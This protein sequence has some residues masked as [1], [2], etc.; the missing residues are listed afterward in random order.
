MRKLTIVAAALAMVLVFA[1]AAVAKTK[2]PDLVTVTNF[3]AGPVISGGPS[4]CVTFSFDQKVFLTGGD[5]TNFHLVP[6][7]GDDAVDGTSQSSNTCRDRRGDRLITVIFRGDL[8]AADFAR[9][10]VDNSTV[11]SNRQGNAPTNV[12]QAEDI[13]PGTETVNPDL[14]SVTVNCKRQVA[15]YRFDE[16]LSQ[17]DVIQDTS[18]LRLYFG[19]T[20][21][22]SAQRVDET[23]NRKVLRASF[24]G[25]LPQGKNLRG[26]RGAFVTAG[27]VVGGQP[28]NGPGGEAGN[29]FDEVAP[30]RFA[31]NCGG[32][33]SGGP[34]NGGGPGGGGSGSGGSG[35]GPGGSGGVS[36][37]GGGASAGDASAGGGSASA[38][39]ASAGGGSVTAGPISLSR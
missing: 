2:A 3:R 24:R 14:V 29:A 32:S 1:S 16:P 34:G 30:L 33:G 15:F 17:E 10:Y 4:T 35:G 38:G 6:V 8:A 22:A 9:G 37:G 23:G 25:G 12:P 5:R 20:K 39:D 19:D 21:R 13:R 26:A 31:K 28:P 18:G 36:V 11:S 7:D 27:T